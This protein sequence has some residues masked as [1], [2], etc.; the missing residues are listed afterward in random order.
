MWRWRAASCSTPDVPRARPRHA[1][2]ATPVPPAPPR[3]AR[4]SGLRTHPP[5][6]APP[7][8]AP[9][10]PT[11]PLHAPLRSAPPRQARHARHSGLYRLHCRNGYFDC[12]GLPYFPSLRQQLLECY[13]CAGESRHKY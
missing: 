11:L 13:D 3:P 4:D 7:S 5:R 1:P 2:P 6:H 9:V 12:N 8:T 10:P